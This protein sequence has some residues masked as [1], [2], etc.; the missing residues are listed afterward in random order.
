[1][2]LK[3]RFF[4]KKQ[5]FELKDNEIFI[6]MKQLGN[7]TEYSIK[8]EDILANKYHIKSSNMVLFSFSIFFIVFFMINFA[9]N[10]NVDETNL[11]VSFLWLFAGLVFL[12]AAINSHENVWNVPTATNQKLKFYFNSPNQLEVNDFID[13]LFR[14]R[15]EYLDSTY[16]KINPNLAYDI[17]FNNFSW[18]KNIQAISHDNYNL[19]IKN[20][21]EIFKNQSN[22]IGF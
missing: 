14:K 6:S 17:Q 19:K 5:F 15:D 22:K 4:H 11:V 9:L 21:D 8:Y 16:G 18:L 7:S 2:M 20:L 12:G 1:M 10:Y 3:Q 13:E